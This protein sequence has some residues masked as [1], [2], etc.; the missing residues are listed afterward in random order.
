MGIDDIM[1]HS[2]LYEKKGKYQHACCDNIDRKSDI[3]VICN[4]TPSQKWMDTTLHEFGHAVYEKYLDQKMPWI[5]REP[6]HIFTTEAIAML[7]GRMASNPVWIS[8]M[9]GV[10]KQEQER[11]SKTSF[12]I[13]R[14]EQLVFSR[15]SQVMYMFEK[16]MYEDPNQDLNALW[17]K[18]VEKYQ[19]MRKPEL[20]NAPDWSTKIHL[21]LYP[22]YYHNY[23]MGALLASQINSYVTK[24]ILK[25]KDVNSQSYFGKKDVGTYFKQ[26]IFT[27][28]RSLYWDDMITKATGEKLTP[29][30][31]MEQFVK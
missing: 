29:K 15:W 31:Y 21:A 30:Y 3:R 24:N 19:M 8:D 25:T 10:S 7:F 18:L 5:Y 9:L 12:K 20:R 14:M 2:D 13:L 28:G 17:W 27:P 1:R 11:I 16:A 6:S 22:A 23:L 26:K 4:I